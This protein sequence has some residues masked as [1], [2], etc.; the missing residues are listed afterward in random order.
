MA[1]AITQDDSAALQALLDSRANP[2]TPYNAFLPLERAIARNRFEIFCMLLD[3]GADFCVRLEMSGAPWLTDYA[4]WHG[5]GRFVQVLLD[6]GAPYD[7]NQVRPPA[8][9]V[10]VARHEARRSAIALLSPRVRARFGLPRDVAR[11]LARAVWA[12]RKLK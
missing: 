8:M 3:A 6:M 2:S 1:R 7:R 12:M 4:C 5:R 11:L 9:A 10:I